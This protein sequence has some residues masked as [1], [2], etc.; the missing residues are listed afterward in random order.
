MTWLGCSPSVWIYL[1][2]GW[3]S[4]WPVCSEICQTLHKWRPSLSSTLSDGSEVDWL[5]PHVHLHP[6]WCHCLKKI[7]ALTQKTIWFEGWS[8]IQSTRVSVV[9]THYWG[10]EAAPLMGRLNER[11]V[12]AWMNLFKQ[13]TKVW[14]I[15]ER[16]SNDSSHQKYCLW[17]VTQS[18][19]SSLDSLCRWT[20]C[21]SSSVF[22]G[23]W[24]V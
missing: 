4:V 11:S 14:N 2:R 23:Q 15:K 16:K 24:S 12:I 19:W 7:F 9:L 21:L 5:L 3:C 22:E 18:C 6:C 13:V 10:L 17:S 20:L 1:S 8:P